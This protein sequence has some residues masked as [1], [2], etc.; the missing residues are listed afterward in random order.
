MS[1]FLKKTNT[2]KGIYYQVYEGKHNKE[3]GY[4]TQKSI[5]VIGY[6]EKLKLEGIDNPEEYAKNI[7]KEMEN[8]RK[9]EI[10]KMETSKISNDSET[11]N[12]GYFLIHAFLEKLK[13]KYTIDLFNY[14]R[15]VKYSLYD[16]LCFLIY[17]Q[18]I[19][20]KSKLDEY[21]SFKSKITNST[22]F[23]YDQILDAL[24]ILGQDYISVINIVN[25]QMKHFYKR[26]VNTLFF[27]CT[28]YYFE[29]DKPFE[30]K[31]KGPSK[32]KRTDPIIGQA[33]LLDATQ[34]PLSMQMYPGNQS[35]KPMIRRLISEMKK[36]FNIKGKTIQIADKGLNCG[37]NIFEAIKNNDGYIYSQ[38][39]KML[40]DKEKKW[41]ILDKDYNEIYKDGEL[42]F[43]SKSCIDDFEYKFEYEGKMYTHKFKQK[44]IVFRS[45]DLESKHLTEINALVDKALNLCKS[46]AKKEQ[47]GDAAKY[48][49]FKQIDKNGEIIEGKNI[50]F[51]KKDL[52]E[53]EKKLC[54]F[55]MLITSEIDEPNESI[56]NAYHHLWR[57]E[58]SFRILKSTLASRPVFLRD[59]NKIYGH[60]LICYLSL[61]A[62]RYLELIVFDDKIS[63]QKIVNFIRNFE[64]VS[65]PNGFL[66]CLK[67]KDYLEDIQK[68]T[69]ITINNKYFHEDLFEKLEKTTI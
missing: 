59:K 18:I 57:I 34:I 55:N 32:E 24:E 13:I 50:K 60:F 2:K 68:L 16:I 46:K 35:E 66:N 36:N 52:I 43:K 44:R 7:V 12:A 39:V 58:Q 9:I 62:I 53:K 31:Q 8:N 21:K 1:Y 33:L 37:Q 67:Q 51:L 25:D 19:D 45:K 38:S 11:K 26:N 29:I 5:K 3:K 41:V 14:G 17:A 27:D 47:F 22:N 15:K 56:Y 65:V 69:S 30:D 48:I 40:S 28:N 42:I 6:Y 61:L 4:T 64:V 20:P 10:E 63:Y 49:D 54:G 23:S